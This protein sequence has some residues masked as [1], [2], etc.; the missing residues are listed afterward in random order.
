MLIEGCNIQS[1]F[2][3]CFQKYS[4]PMS[5]SIHYVDLYKNI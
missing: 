3:E 4:I 2:D 1:V 5:L